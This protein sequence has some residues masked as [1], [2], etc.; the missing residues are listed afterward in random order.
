MRFVRGD[1]VWLEDDQGRRYVDALSGIAV[2]AIGHGHPH[3]TAAI[4]EQAGQLLHTSNLF[5]IGP[6]ERLAE[7]LCERTFGDRV[8]FC[9]SGAEANETVFKLLRLWCN[10]VHGG[11]KPR[12]IA[13][14]GS[15]HGRT[16]GALSMTG[17]AAYRDPFAPLPAVDFVPYGDVDALVAAM[18]PDVA[19]VVI[20]PLQGEGGVAVPPAG[21]LAAV[22]RLCDEHDALLC[23]DEVQVGVGRTGALF[24][25]QLDDVSPDCMQ[26]AK[27]L[28]GGVP[29]GAT[30]MTDRCAELLVP[31]THASTFGGNHLAC[32][33]A[34][35]VLDIVDDP[36]LLA[37]VRERGDQLQAGL[38]ALFGD[39]AVEVRG[40]GL[41]VGVEL[42]EPPAPIMAGA[43]EHGLVVGAAG[44]NTYDWPHRWLSPKRKLTNC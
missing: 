38:R 25:H 1:G 15:F 32:A 8:Y 44:R 37:N 17:T 7:R 4:S 19:G 34:N 24:C 23:F 11:S 40:R 33:A 16:V 43:L 27:G 42:P 28:G 5:H 20:E 39:R 36:A 13:A 14:E 2:N 9:N 30:V 10:Q 31:G 18:G 22:R 6:Q 12:I 35:A 29:I 26:L 41:L 21:Y 3:L